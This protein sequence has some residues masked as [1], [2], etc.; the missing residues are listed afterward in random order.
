MIYYLILQDRVSD[1]QKLYTAI[2]QK[3]RQR[4]QLQYDYIDCYI[5]V[6]TGEGHS[7]A[8]ATKI[9]DQYRD[10]G[11]SGWRKLF[12]DVAQTLGKN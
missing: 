12:R 3:D 10:Y 4:F 5:D 9:A 7:Y 6:C 8:T 1:A 11:V 2:S